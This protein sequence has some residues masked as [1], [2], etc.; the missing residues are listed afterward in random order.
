[1]DVDNGAFDGVL[2]KVALSGLETVGPFAGRGVIA[3]KEESDGDSGNQNA[4]DDES[5]TPSAV[6]GHVL[7]V[8]E[9]IVDGGHDEVCDT[10]T[11]VTETGGQGVGSAD[12]VLVKETSGPYLARYERS[13]Q[14]TDEK[15][16]GVEA[17]RARDG[18]SKEG[19]NGTDEKASSKGVAGTETIASR[20]SNKTNQKGGSQSNNVR[21]GNLMLREVHILGDNIAEKWRECIPLI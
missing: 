18:S 19:R 10:T 13:T 5:D 9:G 16:D 2:A 6:G 4:R 17:G 21:V 15:S 8:E 3:A 7:V 20:T 14:N 11:S 1:M 12:D